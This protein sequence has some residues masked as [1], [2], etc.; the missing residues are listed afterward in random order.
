MFE[1]KPDVRETSSCLAVTFYA[2]NIVKVS[3][4]AIKLPRPATVLNPFTAIGM[5]KPI[6][7]TARTMIRSPICS[8]WPSMLRVCFSTQT[9]NTL[10]PIPRANKIQARLVPDLSYM[11]KI[12][13]P[14]AMRKL[15]R[16]NNV[17]FLSKNASNTK[18]INLLEQAQANVLNNAF[19]QHATKCYAVYQ[20]NKTKP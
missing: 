8:F 5:K 7:Q 17:T 14:P 12:S 13:N 3:C 20:S 18:S 19:A 1:H 6:S 10:P 9:L 16:R 2:A 11:E 15:S 4:I